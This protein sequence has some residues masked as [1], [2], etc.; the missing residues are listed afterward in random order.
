MDLVYEEGQLNGTENG[1]LVTVAPGSENM[2]RGVIYELDV[3]SVSK[4]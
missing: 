1:L 3:V 2:V 4:D